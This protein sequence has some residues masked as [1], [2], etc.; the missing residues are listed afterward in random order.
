MIWKC[1]SKKSFV[2][3]K[4]L[5]SSGDKFATPFPLH[6][7]SVDSYKNEFFHLGD[8]L[9]IRY[10]PKSVS[11]KKKM[12]R[13]EG[14]WPTPCPRRRHISLILVSYIGTRQE[15]NSSWCSQF[16][17]IQWVVFEM[18]KETLFG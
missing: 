16:F 1:D 11:K 17:S 8:L 18:I 14:R 15:Y 5:F 2:Y 7:E 12:G 10:Y 9:G 13:G 6:T 3:E 4:V